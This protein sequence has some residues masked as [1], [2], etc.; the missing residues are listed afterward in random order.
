MGGKI[1]II[2]PYLLNKEYISSSVKAGPWNL[3]TIV[4]LGSLLKSSIQGEP[5][6]GKAEARVKYESKF[7]EDSLAVFCWIR[8]GVIGWTG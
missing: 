6:T 3:M 5:F 1:S 7:L 8:D 2:V 4:V